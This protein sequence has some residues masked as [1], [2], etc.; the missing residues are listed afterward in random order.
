MFFDGGPWRRMAVRTG[1]RGK[2]RGFLLRGEGS[3]SALVS[4]A[5][6]AQHLLGC[7]VRKVAVSRQTVEGHKS[8]EH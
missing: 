5:Q 1:Y 6:T 3:I 2:H 4:P 7:C 8:W